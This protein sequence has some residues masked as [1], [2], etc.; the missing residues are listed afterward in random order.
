MTNDSQ[1][2][3]ISYKSEEIDKAKEIQQYL[4]SKGCKCWRAPDSLN[5]RGTQDYGNDIFQAIRDS[6]CLLFVLSNRALCSDWVRKEVKYALE[7]CHKPV[8]PYLV[9]RV[10]TVKYD[11]DE[12]MI[13]LSLQKQLL[14]ENQSG[15]MSVILPYVQ[16]YIGGGEDSGG[17]ENKT[18][19][20]RSVDCK[21]SEGDI[22]CLVSEADVY[23]ERINELAHIN[24][25]SCG[26]DY[27]FGLRKKEINDKVILAVRRLLSAF[28]AIVEG[29][30]SVE[31]TV[32]KDILSKIY[33]LTYDYGDLFTNEVFG[34]VESHAK[35]DEPWACFVLHTKYY[36]PGVSETNSQE[37][38]YKMLAVS[39]RDHDNPFAA[40]RMG[41]CFQW[42][43]GCDVSGLTAKFWYDRAL[44]RGCAEAYHWLGCLYEWG[45]WDIAPD[46]NKAEDCYRTGMD[47]G[48]SSSCCRL[49]QL[50]LGVDDEAAAEA[51]REGSKR[52]D[53]K[54]F[55]LLVDN[56]ERFPAAALDRSLGD[57]VDLKLC[58]DCINDPKHRESQAY[59]RLNSFSETLSTAEDYANLTDKVTEAGADNISKPEN[60]AFDHIMSGMAQKSASSFAYMGDLMIME[61]LKRNKNMLCVN[62]DQEQVQKVLKECWSFFEDELKKSEDKMSRFV[63]AAIAVSKR[64]YKD[65]PKKMQRRVVNLGNYFKEE[66]F[67]GSP[68]W[69]A[70]TEPSSFFLKTNMPSRL[71]EFHYLTPFRFIDA[72]HRCPAAPDSDL[73][74][75]QK[76]WRLLGLINYEWVDCEQ[77]CKGHG[78]CL[79][80]GAAE[81]S[82]DR[83]RRI[84]HIF[85]ELSTLI[86]LPNK[87]SVLASSLKVEELATP[88]AVGPERDLESL[89]YDVLREGKKE[90]EELKESHK[91]LRI[92]YYLAKEEERYSDPQLDIALNCYRTSYALGS[93]PSVALK[94]ATLF[95]VH[96]GRFRTEGANESVIYGIKDALFKAIYSREWKAVPLFLETALFGASTGSANVEADF[97][98]IDKAD[99]IVASMIQ[100][101][102]PF[103]A[104]M[105]QYDTEYRVN[106]LVAKMKIALGMAKIYMDEKLC[107]TSRCEQKWGVSTLLDRAKAIFWLKLAKKIFERVPDDRKEAD[108][109][110][111]VRF[112][113][114]VVGTK[115]EKLEKEG[116][117]TAKTM[118]T[119]GEH[120]NRSSDDSGGVVASGI[121]NWR[122]QVQRV[123][124]EIKSEIGR[125]PWSFFPH[126]KLEEDTVDVAVSTDSTALLLNVLPGDID[127]MVEQKR[128]I[129]CYWGVPRIGPRVITLDFV[130]MLQRIGATL[131][132]LEPDSTVEIGIVASASTCSEIRQALGA[133][134]EG[135]DLN[136]LSYD[137]LKDQIIEIFVRHEDILSSPDVVFDKAYAA[138]ERED[139][140]VSFPLF[141]KLAG[142][143]YKKAYGYVGLAYELG[144]GVERDLAT[145]TEYYKKAIAAHEHLG[146]YRLGMLYQ[147]QG[148]DLS[149]YKV[150]KEAADEGYGTADDYL[151]LAQ[152]FENGR[153]V[154]RDLQQAVVY[155]RMAMHKN[156]P[157]RSR[158]AR[159]ALGRLGALYSEDDF[160]VQLP[161]EVTKAEPDRLYSLA[162]EKLDDFH[163]PDV[164]FAFACLQLAAD[165]GH[166]L[167]A[168]KLALLYADKKLPIHD[169]TMYKKYSQMASDG[170]VDQVEKEPSYAYD[171]GCA[172]QFGSG[173]VQD[174]Q[175]AVACFRIG[176][177]ES[178][179]SC[180]WRLGVMLQKQGRK[181]EAFALLFSAARHGQGMAMF[182]VAKCFEK[183]I[184][185]KKDMEQA[186]HWYEQCSESHYAAASDARCRLEAL[187]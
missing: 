177:R 114:C 92:A 147:E 146:T 95:F 16:K 150:Y 134:G 72:L 1:Y 98:A 6:S 53:A 156:D 15:D 121:S 76:I 58:V 170:M 23:I 123:V 166:A 120:S 122:T 137:S 19:S 173:C 145:A 2:V 91:L 131:R 22:S 130:T 104:F 87:F 71:A 151:Q 142:E 140:A 61:V 169:G 54:S 47:R 13:S 135:S 112:W 39:V 144:E 78:V 35:N 56:A 10:P 68:F 117:V 31:T 125:L 187:G 41:I 44:A 45:T 107:C 70:L 8:I 89:V 139:Y 180:E 178:D 12:L 7:R 100:N 18:R 84:A 62:V 57:K 164:P 60:V 50:K 161:G 101:D 105:M 37:L 42:G 83:A 106:Y 9:D 49:G 86:S 43:I 40:I 136:L 113:E 118:E 5:M 127:F 124:E 94:L 171:A 55:S 97:Q 133:S 186:I 179:E 65:D 103:D 158:D 110:L 63:K 77:I 26:D 20:S 88:L 167:A 96:N 176:V 38:T 181:E 73:E 29:V 3:F 155:Y 36:K 66:C 67:K 174:E 99:P 154:R 32:A 165:K 93:A 48:V 85:F 138:Y 102:D 162:T 149:A 185:T 46:N 59:E 129:S 175:K 109:I 79:T 80:S 69:N 132:R 111:S 25:L 157:I 172:Y 153:V 141:M 163:D 128:G 82:I 152:M 116:F 21:V 182:E 51:F 64:E 81:T 52:G 184:G 14:N 75:V 183:G 4:E 115:I 17:D 126:V 143:G 168:S 24:F 119:L 27:P 74:K 11:T 34:L 159:E 148:D 108:G 90:V 28:S 30:V 160:R 33:R